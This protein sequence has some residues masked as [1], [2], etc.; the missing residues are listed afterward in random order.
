MELDDATWPERSIA[1]LR[2]QGSNLHRDPWQDVI[3][4][5]PELDPRLKNPRR[6]CM[7]EP[8][9]DRSWLD[10]MHS[11]LRTCAFGDPFPDVH[12]SDLFAETKVPSKRKRT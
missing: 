6:T 3:A 1:L 10:E 4:S 11:V 2:E 8:H 5:D 12:V 7:F 9:M